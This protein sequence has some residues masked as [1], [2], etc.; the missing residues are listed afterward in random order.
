MK[1]NLKY[2]PERVLYTLQYL[3]AGIIFI[4]VFWFSFFYLLYNLGSLKS[5]YLEISPC[6]Y[7]VDGWSA[8]FNPSTKASGNLYCILAMVTSLI[9]LI[10]VSWKLR[11]STKGDKRH[12]LIDIHSL[13]LLFPVLLAIAQLCLWLGGQA[14]VAP[15]F[16]EIFSA[17][18]CAGIPVFQCLS[19]Y[20]LPNNH[21]FFNVL[22]NILFH[23][24]SDHVFTG[25]L[26]SLMAYLVLVIWAYFRFLKQ[27]K[28][29]VYA[30][31]AAVVLAVQFPLWGFGFQARGYEI[32]ALAQW[33]AFVLLF[34][35]INTGNK[36]YLV[37]NSVFCV[38]GY[39]TI[40]SFLYY[41]IAQ[42]LFIA[43]YQIWQKKFDIR[44]WKYQALAILF[45]FYFYLPALCFSGAGAFLSNKY[46]SPSNASA[47]EFFYKV[48]YFFRSYIEYGFANSFFAPS[49]LSF[50]L[51]MMPVLLFLFQKK[52]IGIFYVVQVVSFI[53]IVFLMKRY[54]FH[55]NLIGQ[56]SI[57]LTISLVSAYHVFDKIRLRYF[58][59]VFPVLMVLLAVFFFRAGFKG[60]SN[61]LYFDDATPYYTSFGQRLDSLP[62]GVIVGCS[63]Q[64]FYWYY[65]CRN[66]HIIVHRCPDGSEDYFVKEQDEL[67]PTGIKS[68]AYKLQSKVMDYELYRKRIGD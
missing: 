56:F 15:S 25:R 62:M 34:D 11:G 46:V 52:W 51:F 23:G 40:P 64:S 19:Y 48:V 37:L 4:S 47:I 39:I 36:K 53:G 7:N 58:K 65:L 49:I 33:G 22:N 28:N 6:M 68:S 30:F 21:V 17:V 31:L 67:F 35:Y 32:Y 42:I 10:Y 60:M 63:D 26:I 3:F 66:K 12:L 54:P 5:W 50:A 16:D 43:L 24:A 9:G 59:T 13:D 44:F 61:N 55:R 2:N 18:N 20:M 8:W 29:Q 14:L 41:H 57:V 45:V 38:V 27:F 1:I